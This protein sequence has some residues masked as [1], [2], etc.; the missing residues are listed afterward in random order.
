MKWTHFKE[1][2]SII[3]PEN[4]LVNVKKYCLFIC[5]F[6]YIFIFIN[7]YYVRHIQMPSGL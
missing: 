3:L 2:F 1:L 6:L 5:W 7:F 4:V